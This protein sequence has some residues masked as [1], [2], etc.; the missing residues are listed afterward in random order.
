MH[1]PNF[2]T[3]LLGQIAYT[4]FKIQPQ[5][6]THLHV[7]FSALFAIFIGAH[8]S[9]GRP[10]SAAKPSNDDDDDEHD[11]VANE[12][13]AMPPAFAVIMP[14]FAAC[15]L[16]AM[17]YLIVYAGPELLN[18]ILAVYFFVVGAPC[19]V[20]LG[21]DALHLLHSLL[22]PSVYV[23]AGRL[24][25]VDTDARQVRSDTTQT[26]NPAVKHPT[27]SSPLPGLLAHFPLPTPVR[28]ATW[29]GL[30]HACRKYAV[31]LHVRHV[32]SA[33]YEG[34]LVELLSIPAAIFLLSYAS[35]VSSPWYLTNIQG[36]AFVYFTMQILSP[37]TF[38]VGSLLLAM[39]FI[40]D[41]IMVFKTPMMVTVA[42]NLD[43]PIKMMFPRPKLD[44]ES[45]L[46][47][48]TR[49]MAMLGLGDIVVP[50]ILCGLALRFDLWRHYVSKQKRSNQ[51]TNSN[52]DSISASK[53][54]PADMADQKMTVTKAP[55]TKVTDQWSRA[56]WTGN[57]LR[58]TFGSRPTFTTNKFRVATFPKP[59]F[60]ASMTGYIIGMI[61][62]LVVMT[63]WQHAQPALL[64]LVLCV[65]GSLWLTGL[66]KGEVKLMRT[67]RD[68]REN[69]DDVEVDEEKEQSWWDWI[70][71]SFD[72]PNDVLAVKQV[73]DTNTRDEDKPEG[74]KGSRPSTSSQQETDIK[75][76]DEGDEAKVEATET[77][78]EVSSL[79]DTDTSAWIKLSF[80]RVEKK[81]AKSV[82]AKGTNV[83]RS[84]LPSWHAASTVEDTE[85]SGKRLRTR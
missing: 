34:S 38:V 16:T 20:K 17:Y 77:T 85:R 78:E 58:Y 28:Q 42:V 45:E 33:Q 15:M 26:A 65:V 10:S 3:E 49:D 71:R 29:F 72:L 56:F 7:L 44:S 76:A 21:T 8:A 46:P 19:V 12:M 24:W 52:E 31:K 79:Q 84:S 36:L 11:S 60:L 48:H 37:G 82:E 30:D 40:Y 23:E 6:T 69:V 70:K 67:F 2:I 62:T 27:R 39:L 9:L 59:Y 81:D 35:F 41:I 73:S 61:L 5:L 55:Y 1:L 53:A 68:G 32:I 54:A 47:E 50:G 83:T 80:R 25:T 63:Y 64:Y 66:C 57:L 4:L 14:V 43:V 22:A 75:G 13:Q 74:D 51:S 18:R